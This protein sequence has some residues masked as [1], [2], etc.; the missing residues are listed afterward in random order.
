MKFLVDTGASVV[1]LTR[2]D[3]KRLRI[4]LDELVYDNRITTAGGEVMSASV[5]LDHIRI[6]NVELKDIDAVIL[7]ED[8]LDNSLLGM[9]FLGGLYS[10]EFKGNTMIIRQ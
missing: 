9:S 7:E 6:G 4:N 1:A 2:H 8:V 3:A 5:R 10:Y